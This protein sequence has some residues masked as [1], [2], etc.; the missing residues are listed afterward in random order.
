[1]RRVISLYLPHWPSDRMRRASKDAP[2]RDKPLVTAMMQGQ[3]RVIASVDQ[4]AAQLGLSRGMAVT[5]A[6]S[7]VPD[8]TVIEATSDDDEAALMRLAL[9][10]INSR[11]PCS[12]NMAWTTRR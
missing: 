11:L 8:L 1:M 9:W 7:L 12:A 2:P 5:H 6:Q 4:A 3:R 10:C